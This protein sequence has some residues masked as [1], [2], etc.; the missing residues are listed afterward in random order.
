VAVW[1]W[2]VSVN[3]GLASQVEQPVR[4]RG[5]SRF[6]ARSLEHELEH[7]ALSA[8]LCALDEEFGPAPSELVEKY[9]GLWP[10]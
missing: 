10:S 9:D 5:L 6:G 3:E 4:D 1:K 8:Y 7:D 2:S